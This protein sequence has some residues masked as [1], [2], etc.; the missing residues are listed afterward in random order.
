MPSMEPESNHSHPSEEE[1]S[2]L[3]QTIK[4]KDQSWL[5][6][7]QIAIQEAK[8]NAK[9]SEPFDK[10]S[11]SVTSGSKTSEGSGTFSD[12][13][14]DCSDDEHTY[15]RTDTRATSYAARDVVMDIDDFDNLFSCLTCTEFVETEPGIGKYDGVLVEW[16][17]EA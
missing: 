15:P 7:A 13:E 10:C 6:Q 5:K 9:S 2:W 14:S 12:S 8:K 16:L 4:K 3:Q 17:S 11:G 1:S